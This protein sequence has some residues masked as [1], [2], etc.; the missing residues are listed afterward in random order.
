MQNPSDIQSI[1]SSGPKEIFPM[2]LNSLQVQPNTFQEIQQDSQNFSFLSSNQPS[3]PTQNDPN[4]QT[5]TRKQY[6]MTKTREKWTNEE[7][8]KFLEALKFNRDWKKIQEI[9]KT[10]TIVQVRFLKN[11]NFLDS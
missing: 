1:L 9:V 10:K 4:Y 6:T 11:L 5:K 8:E 2:N 3:S 7:H